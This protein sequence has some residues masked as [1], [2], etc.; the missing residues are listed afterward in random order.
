MSEITAIIDELKII[1]DGDAWHGP[2]LKENLSGISAV[3]AASK[4]MAT[5][6]SIWELVLHIAAWEE[7]FLRRLE[8]Q[9]LVEPEEGDFPPVGESGDAAWQQTLQWLDDV[10]E[11]LLARIAKLTVDRLD[12]IV[13]GKDYTV[14]Y[15]LHGI[16][17]H[18][19]Y[20]SGQI[21]LL[22]K[23]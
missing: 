16:V 22:K 9:P 14:G 2:S 17:R 19:V 8:G 20:H 23:G 5:A 12:E 3:Q 15:L 7:V 18:H 10:H 6:H 13:V 11:R 21:G 4:P 1:H